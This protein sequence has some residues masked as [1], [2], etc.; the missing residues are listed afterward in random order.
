MIRRPPRSTLFP[1]TTLFRSISPA[2]IAWSTRWRS[3][4][5]RSRR[6]C[7]NGGQR[8]CRRAWPPCC[9]DRLFVRI[10]RR[11]GMI[12]FRLVA[13]GPII[14][15]LAGAAQGWRAGAL[16]AFVHADLAGVA[17]FLVIARM[18]RVG[19]VLRGLP[20]WIDDVVGWMAEVGHVAG[21]L[22]AI[23]LV[24]RRRRGHFFAVHFCLQG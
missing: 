7:K 10:Q 3:C 22:A 23:L 11:G 16:A 24:F 20:M 8:R 18:W 9:R 1:Y 5:P 19:L 17:G 13:A 21:H 14:G 2:L 15:Q 6:C 4:R 12:R